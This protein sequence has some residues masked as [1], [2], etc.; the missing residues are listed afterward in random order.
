[1]ASTQQVLLFG[2]AHVDKLP[3][4]KELF[5]LSKTRP[6]LREFLRGACDVVQ[7]HLS[8]LVPEERAVFGHF[9]DLLELAERHVTQEYPDEMLG[10][11]LLTTIQI[12]DF[13][14]YV[15]TLFLVERRQQ[16]LTHR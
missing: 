16:I 1:M 4:I 7:C 14:W 12:G 15:L 13:L 3:A 6:Q 2:D 10:Y 5:S 11:V 9:G 8:T